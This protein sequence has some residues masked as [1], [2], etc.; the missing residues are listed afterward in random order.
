MFSYSDSWI[1][2]FKIETFDLKN[3]GFKYS[4]LGIAKFVQKPRK[5]HKIIF[6]VKLKNI[7]TN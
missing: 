4:K 3:N 1:K 2:F 7:I 6:P 5:F